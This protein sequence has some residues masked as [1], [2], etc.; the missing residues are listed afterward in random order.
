MSEPTTLQIYPGA[1]GELTLYDDDGESLGYRDGADPKTIW[2][3]A[4]WDDHA[5]RL[6][7][8]ADRRLKKWPGGKR[9]FTIKVVGRTNS[10]TVEFHGLR[11]TVVF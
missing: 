3:C 8:E 10:K 1:S 11:E 4:R 5:R 7:I 2:I 6:V 9:K